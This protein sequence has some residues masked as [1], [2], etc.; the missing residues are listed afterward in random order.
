LHPFEAEARLPASAQQEGKAKVRG[1]VDVRI[2]AASSG[3]V[4]ED[5]VELEGM[6]LKS[7]Q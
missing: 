3:N 5:L 4:Q 1:W 2:N 7:H 6:Q